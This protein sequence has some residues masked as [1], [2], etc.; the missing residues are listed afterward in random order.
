MTEQ[1]L[2]ELKIHTFLNHPN[3]VQIYGYF[4]DEENIYVLQELCTGGQLYD[5]VVKRRRIS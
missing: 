3:I 1:L 2:Q 5:L 4:A